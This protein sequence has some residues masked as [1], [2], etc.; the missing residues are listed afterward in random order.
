MEIYNA[1]CNSNYIRRTSQG[2]ANVGSNLSFYLRNVEQ[3][4]A[5]EIFQ[6]HTTFYHNFC[7]RTRE[8]AFGSQVTKSLQ[9]LCVKYICIFFLIIELIKVIFILALI[10]IGFFF[11]SILYTD[12]GWLD[13]LLENEI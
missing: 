2:L 1:K 11:L 13:F 6:I 12:K 7:L 9:R 3:S 8:C 4:K 10:T 5:C